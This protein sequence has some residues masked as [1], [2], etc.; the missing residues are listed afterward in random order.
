MLEM[1]PTVD[2]NHVK[3]GQGQDTRQQSHPM[4]QSLARAS[5]G[6]SLLVRGNW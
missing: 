6:S 2:R 5:E 3:H 1:D 4:A